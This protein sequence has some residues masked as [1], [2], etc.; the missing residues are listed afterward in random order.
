MAGWFIPVLKA[1]LPHVGDIVGRTDVHASVPDND[2]DRT[3]SSGF[4]PASRP[5]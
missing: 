2:N 4:A 5:K 3:S 1:V